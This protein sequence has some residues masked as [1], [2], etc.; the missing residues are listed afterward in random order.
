MFRKFPPIPRPG[1]R[2]PRASSGWWWL[3]VLL[4]VAAWVVILV[5][6]W[7]RSA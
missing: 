1:A 7:L 4:P 5:C 2:P 6:G 3:A